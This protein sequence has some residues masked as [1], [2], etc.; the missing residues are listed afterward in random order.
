[1]GYVQYWKKK[2]LSSSLFALV[3][4]IVI[5]VVVVVTLVLTGSTRGKLQPIE[6]CALSSSLQIDTCILHS[7]TSYTFFYYITVKIYTL[8][9][10]K[11]IKYVYFTPF[12]WNFKYPYVSFFVFVFWRKNTRFAYILPGTYDSYSTSQILHISYI[13]LF[14]IFWHSMQY[15]NQWLI[16]FYLPICQSCLNDSS[17][18]FYG[19]YKWVVKLCK[20]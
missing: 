17:I 7:D 11:W 12:V 6:A 19:N 3:N 1:V 4:L 10:S 14:H 16:I 13:G 8:I 20:H 5:G 18:C 9:T 2:K 15:F